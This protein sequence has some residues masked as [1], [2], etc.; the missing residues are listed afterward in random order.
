MHHM[1]WRAKS[2]NQPL[3]DWRVRLYK[4]TDMNYMF[5]KASAF[6]QPLGN[7]RLRS[8]CNTAEMFKGAH[9]RNS[10]P[11]KGLCCAIS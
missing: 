5:Y 9:F 8:N 1:F 4:V 10:R 7:W 11:V 2:F 3:G 6:D